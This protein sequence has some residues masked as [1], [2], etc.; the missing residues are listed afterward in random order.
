MLTRISF[1]FFFKKNFFRVGLSGWH[2]VFITLENLELA[3]LPEY[4]FYWMIGEE[5]FSM[6]CLDPVFLF[7]EQTVYQTLKWFLFFFFEG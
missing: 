7:F 3:S 1:F 6:V 4:T 2:S 5:P